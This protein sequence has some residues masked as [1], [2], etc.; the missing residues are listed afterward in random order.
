M[1]HIRHHIVHV[2]A[3]GIGAAAGLK[4]YRENVGGVEY[5]HY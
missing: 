2:V 5:C 1:G 3:E 4:D